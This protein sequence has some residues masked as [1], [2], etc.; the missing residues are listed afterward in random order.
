M[1]MPKFSSVKLVWDTERGQTKLLMH[2]PSSKNVVWFDSQ[3]RAVEMEQRVDQHVIQIRLGD[4]QQ[5]G[6]IKRPMKLRYTDRKNHIQNT[7]Q[8]TE[9]SDIKMPDQSVFQL[10]PPPGMSIETL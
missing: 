1:P 9:L 3:M 8:I 5:L 10:S 2:T 6:K 4:F 7:L